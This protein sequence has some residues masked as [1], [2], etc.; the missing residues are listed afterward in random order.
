M[1]FLLKI[2]FLVR[3]LSL[4]FFL[5][6]IFYALFSTFDG[7]HH[8]LLHSICHQIPNRSPVLLGHTFSLCF[9][10]A[11][12]YPGFFLAILLTT[13]LPYTIRR[14]FLWLTCF[15][16]LFTIGLWLLKIDLPSELRFISGLSIGWA[17]YEVVLHAFQ[18]FSTLLMW[19]S[20]AI[21]VKAKQ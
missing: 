9:R 6:V 14:N 11:G 10:C 13:I 1:R 3:I 20:S 16:S 15:I 19:I 4:M 5:S 21:R 7:T 17:T 12:I 18:G 8:N 2:P